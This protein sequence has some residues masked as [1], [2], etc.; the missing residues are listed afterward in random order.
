MNED[1]YNARGVGEFCDFRLISPFTSETI[2][3]LSVTV[4]SVGEYTAV[5][6][7]TEYLQKLN[8]VRTN[9]P[10]LPGEQCGYHGL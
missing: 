4:E 8:V 10:V 3:S 7:V 1:E 6:K 2:I 5:S 9:S